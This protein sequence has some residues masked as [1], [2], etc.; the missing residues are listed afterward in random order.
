MEMKM[1][2]RS[3]LRMM[4]KKLNIKLQTVADYIGV[5]RPAVSMFECYKMNLTQENIKKYY[6]LIKLESR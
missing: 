1:D 3:Y 5:S 6:E 2:D 4:R